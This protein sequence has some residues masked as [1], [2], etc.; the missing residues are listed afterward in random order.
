VL[1]ML[2][3][4]TRINSVRF[5]EQSKSGIGPDVTAYFYDDR[6]VPQHEMDITDVN[7]W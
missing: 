3:L 5:V 4:N 2:A 7:T 1:T 6:N